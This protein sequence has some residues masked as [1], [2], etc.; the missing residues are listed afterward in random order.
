MMAAPAA[1]VLIALRIAAPLDG[2]M[3]P[4][5]PVFL[6]SGQRSGPDAHSR[7][8]QLKESRS[9]KLANWKDGARQGSIETLAHLR[10][11]S[12]GYVF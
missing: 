1:A 3:F 4:K 7:L 8:F 12:E 2:N 6:S 11:F 5:T 9:P 10:R